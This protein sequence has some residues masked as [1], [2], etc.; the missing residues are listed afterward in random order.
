MNEFKQ[1]SASTSEED[2]QS[3]SEMESD[4][5]NAREQVFLTMTSPEKENLLKKLEIYDIKL[6]D[7]TEIWYKLPVSL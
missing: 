3:W 5:Q 1:L 6:S 2:M 4:A 7:G